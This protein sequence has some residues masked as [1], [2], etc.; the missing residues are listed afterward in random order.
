MKLG[1]V[2]EAGSIGPPPLFEQSQK[3]RDEVREHTVD[4]Q[5]DSHRNYNLG[6]MVEGVNR[7]NTESEH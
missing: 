7:M 3:R 1:S 6:K 2:I 5:S 4:V